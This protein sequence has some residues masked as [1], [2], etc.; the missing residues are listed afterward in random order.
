MSWT[1]AFNPAIT[2]V[3]QIIPFPS[4]QPSREWGHKPPQPIRYSIINSP[5]NTGEAATGILVGP[6]QLLHALSG[7]GVNGDD[8]RRGIFS[9]AILA[10]NEH[11]KWS[12]AAY[13]FRAIPLPVLKPVFTREKRLFV[14][15]HQYL[16]KCYILLQISSP[17]LMTCI[18][19]IVAN[20]LR[21]FDRL[22][23]NDVI[24]TLCSVFFRFAESFSRLQIWSQKTTF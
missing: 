2:L 4:H 22:T 11:V 9:W 14:L 7:H 12:S 20:F 6:T 15:F 5:S 19:Y 16:L 1:I 13:L 18:L 3:F 17:A 23:K 21:G 8:V 24:V 10:F